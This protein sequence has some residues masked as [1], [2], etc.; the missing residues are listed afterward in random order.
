MKGV[1]GR[2]LGL[3]NTDCRLRI[4]SSSSRGPTAVGEVRVETASHK[5]LVRMEVRTGRWFAQ[6]DQGNPKSGYWR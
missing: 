4:E 2:V 5:P 1:G 6:G 3:G